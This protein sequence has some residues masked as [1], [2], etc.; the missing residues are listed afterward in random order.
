MLKQQL[1][2]RSKHDNGVWQ[3]SKGTNALKNQQCEIYRIKIEG[4][5]A[6]ENDVTVDI[7]E[8]FPKMGSELTERCKVDVDKNSARKISKAKIG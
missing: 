5:R 6:N 7:T 3:F 2:N 4:K 8:S 1:G